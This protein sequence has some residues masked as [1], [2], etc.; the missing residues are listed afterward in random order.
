MILPKWSTFILQH[1]QNEALENAHQQI[2]DAFQHAATNEERMANLAAIQT[3]PSTIILTLNPFNNTITPSFFHQSLGLT[4]GNIGPAK[5]I[6]LTGFNPPATP[7]YFNLEKL[8]STST[9]TFSFPSLPSFL[10]THSTNI[11][12]LKS[13]DVDDNNKHTI[14]HA[15][16]LPPYLAQTILANNHTYDPWNILPLIIKAIALCCPDDTEE[17]DWSIA[18][19]YQHILHTLWGF[20]HTDTIPNLPTTLSKMSAPKKASLPS[21]SPLC[22]SLPSQP[23]PKPLTH[24]PLA[25][26]GPPRLKPC[27]H[28][29]AAPNLGKYI[30]PPTHPQLH[31]H[32]LPR[33]IEKHTPHFHN[34]NIP[35]IIQHICNN[36]NLPPLQASPFKFDRT[37]AAATHNTLLLQSF[38]FNT[39]VATQNTPHTVLSYGSEFKPSHIIAPLLQQH[40]HWLKI[41]DIV[42]NGMSYP[43]CDITKEER[44]T[45]ID[46]MLERGNHKSAHMNTGE[47]ALNKAFDN[48]VKYQWAIPI[49]PH[50]IKYIPGASV[51]SLGVATQWSINA[52]NEHIIKQQMTHDCTFPGPSGQ[53]C[54]K[55]R[56]I[57]EL[58]KECTYGHTF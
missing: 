47:A 20:C 36:T 28:P 31:L 10:S 41:K 13:I 57:K 8:Q 40:H 45:N 17:N 29:T 22:S 39:D 23:P 11:D 50:C 26:V 1:P 24:P 5:C 19:P 48:K 3:S 43:L 33:D 52:Q 53:S 35:K 58:V 30:S 21:P 14:C 49:Q 4:F 55:D 16:L 7:I 46:F 12:T 18:E 27:S 2:I 42:D 37:Q 54:N 15:I 44:T 56:V 6:A 25:P 38:D 51:T 9:D 34:I 32:C